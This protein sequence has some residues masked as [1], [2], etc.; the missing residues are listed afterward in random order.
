MVMAGMEYENKIPFRDV[1]FT[2]MVRDKL[3]R[4][5]EK[6]LGRIFRF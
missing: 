5:I 4:K 2:G 6:A 3:G 1:Y